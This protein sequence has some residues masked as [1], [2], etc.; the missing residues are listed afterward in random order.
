MA[1]EQEQLVA[2]IESAL[3]S[4]YGDASL[5]SMR[6]LFDSY[7]ANKDGKIDKDEL[8]KLLKDVD[9]GNSF[10][11]GAWVKGI[12]EKL[13]ADADKSISWDEFQAVAATR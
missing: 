8:S 12:I 9:I 2:S 3:K 1:S 5:V 6:K 4:K 11:R 7:D 10:T 13:D